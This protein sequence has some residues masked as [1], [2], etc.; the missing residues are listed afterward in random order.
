MCSIKMLKSF[1]ATLYFLGL[2]GSGLGAAH[3]AP[4]P[5]ILSDNMQSF[6]EDPYMTDEK[7]REK[8]KSIYIS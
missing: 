6:T 3:P 4:D 7:F 5:S 1:V 8:G 2:I